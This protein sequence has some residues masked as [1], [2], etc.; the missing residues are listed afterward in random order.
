MYLR[1]Y[2]RRFCWFWQRWTAGAVLLKYVATAS[3][4]EA[5]SARPPVRLAAL[6]RLRLVLDAREFDR[7]PMGG[8]GR[9]ARH[10]RGGASSRARARG[11]ARRSSCS[12]ELGGGLPRELFW[13]RLR[14]RP[15]W[16]SGG[17]LWAALAS[18][19]ASGDKPAENKLS[20]LFYQSFAAAR[21]VRRR[22]FAL[23]ERAR[24]P[25]VVGIFFCSRR[26]S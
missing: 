2:E 19:G 11:A 1:P 15:L 25:L 8:L 9:L 18:R 3:I 13:R 26:A 24:V 23:S 14:A 21:R 16:G 17:G 6:G 4:E 20:A 12:G 7:E 10:G 5:C 22:F